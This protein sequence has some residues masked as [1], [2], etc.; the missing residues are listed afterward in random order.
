MIRREDML[1]LTR[2]MTPARTCIARIAG[3][4]MDQEGFED[5][6]FNVHFLNLKPADRK[7]NLEIAKTVP[8]SRTNEE[9]KEYAFPT[10][11][12]R[13][14][15]MWQLLTALKEKGLKDDG[16]LSV[17]YELIGETYQ[18]QSDY[19]IFMFYGAYDVP[20]KGKDQEWLEGSEE[21]YEF[22]ICAV[23]PLVGEY[24]PGKPEFGFLFPAFSD[25]SSDDTRIDIFRAGGREVQQELV[26]LLLG[27][28]K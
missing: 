22:L 23:S 13:Q 18:A 7:K 8:F 5:G 4:Y 12:A 3:A 21:V 20:V 19:A 6:T 24:E 11:A 28:E 1:E 16:L 10:G 2:R 27:K 25:R 26:K 17:L 9:L 14:K 15:S